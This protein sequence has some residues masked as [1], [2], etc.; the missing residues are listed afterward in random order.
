MLFIGVLVAAI[1][2]SAGSAPPDVVGEFLNRVSSGG[3]APVALRLC[4]LLE[5]P[6][7][8]PTI[9]N[10]TGIWTYNFDGACNHTIVESDNGNGTFIVTSLCP[11][12]P[13]YRG[14]GQIDMSARKPSPAQAYC[15]GPGFVQPAHQRP[16]DVTIMYLFQATRDAYSHV[17][18][19]NTFGCAYM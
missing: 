19:A 13:W 3:A 1:Q 6:A 15:G 14:L 16:P 5:L 18:R 2:A 10:V 17:Y 9:C 4:P 7:R 8:T 11:S 12:D